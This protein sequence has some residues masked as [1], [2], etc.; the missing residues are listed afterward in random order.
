M[1]TCFCGVY[2]ARNLLQTVPKA[3]LERV[4]AG[5]RSEFRKQSTVA[6]DEQWDLV[7]AMLA[8]HFLRRVT[9]WSWP[10]SRCSTPRVHLDIK[11]PS[12]DWP[13]MTVQGNGKR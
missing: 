13:L 1:L 12:L 11:N 2:F 5:L 8:V 10:G 4:A 3:Q 9:S 6:V 7:A